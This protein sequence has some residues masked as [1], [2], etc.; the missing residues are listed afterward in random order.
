MSTTT[1]QKALERNPWVGRKR[2]YDIVKEG[3]IAVG[4]ISLLV[5]ALSAFLGSPNEPAL[6]LQGWAK[7]VPDNFYATTVGELA[8]T[9]E[10]AGY[11]PPYNTG[12]DG[13][14]I[15]PINPAQL[16]GVRIPVDPAQD[17]VIEPLSHQQQ[18]AAVA[19]ALKA[20]KSASGDK[21]N[22]WA[23]NYDTALNDPAGA[24]GDASKVPAGDYG[25]VPALAAGVTAMAQSGA[26]DGVLPAPGQFYNTDNTKQILFLGD[27][28]Y[29]DDKATAA[30]LQGNTWGMMNEP[31]GYPGQTWLAPFSF[32]YQ[33]P[34][35]NSEA[36]S[37][38]AATLTANGDIYIFTIIGIFMLALLTLPFIPG[39]RDIPRWIPIHKLVWKHY[40][41]DNAARQG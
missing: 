14:A 3:A 22:A 38:F 24:D 33:L 40:Y 13:Q 41:R 23:T 36:E 29:M 31:G 39:L 19:L 32:W 7:T 10:S 5:L 18:P 4:V 37:G 26:L 11:G 30:H 25:P 34:V 1:A 17:F 21:H 27:G 9:T 15:G 12:G 20:W 28:S 6:T 8:G 2:R 16:M 35:F